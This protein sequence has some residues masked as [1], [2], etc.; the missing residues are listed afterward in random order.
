MPVALDVSQ[1][2]RFVAIAEAGSFRAAAERLGLTQPTLSWSIRQLENAVGTELIERGA[3]G[4]RLTDMGRVLLPRARLIVSES[5][6]ALADFE[7]LRQQR[8][9][10]LAV[11]VAPMFVEAPF[12]AAS[13]AV[14]SRSPRL[15]IRVIEGYSIDLIAAL[16]QGEIDMAFGGKPQDADAAGVTFE[17]IH[18]QRYAL[19]ARGRHPIFRSPRINDDSVLAYP[20]V[21]FD[22]ARFVSLEEGRFRARG[23]EPPR[24]AARTSSMQYIKALTLYSDFLGYLATDC[25][26][27][28]LAQERLR[29]VPSALM[30]YTATA[31]ILTREGSAQTRAMQAMK[32]ELRKACRAAKSTR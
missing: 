14:L 4:A 10:S 31:G 8:D 28:E 29:E 11:G 9:A 15:N 27:T 7:E 18:R 32:S 26:A 12:A 19:V 5:G 21:M 13:A 30:G 23:L 2:A 1:L 20:W 6:R 3:R 22:A 25:V 17:P 16:K 24:V